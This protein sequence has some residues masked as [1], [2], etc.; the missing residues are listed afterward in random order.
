MIF[1]VNN[2][3]HFRNFPATLQLTQ[4]DLNIE[5]HTLKVSY[6]IGISEMMNKDISFKALLQ[7]ADEA[8]YEAKDNGKGHIM[9]YDSV[10]SIK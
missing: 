6:S 2:S 8:L 4:Q 10:C 7:K 1:F 3:Q 5:D 9:V